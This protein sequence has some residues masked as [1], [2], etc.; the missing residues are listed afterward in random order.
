MTCSHPS[1]CVPSPLPAPALQVHAR[2]QPHAGQSGGDHSG[3]S[4]LGVNSWRP[5]SGSAKTTAASPSAIPSR[6]LSV[7]ERLSLLCCL[8]LCASVPGSML[9]ETG[10]GR[11]PP[12]AVA[13][14]LTLCPLCPGLPSPPGLFPGPE[15]LQ[16]DSVSWGLWLAPR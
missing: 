13:P 3:Q 10:P 4:G 15:E 6:Q 11:Q 14:L 9:L 2:P 7:W 1:T 5:E 16:G 12:G 8:R